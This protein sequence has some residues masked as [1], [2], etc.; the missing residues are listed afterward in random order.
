MSVRKIDREAEQAVLGTVLLSDRVL[1]ALAEEGLRPEHFASAQHRTIFTA[2]LSLAERAE[3]VDGQTLLSELKRSRGLADAGGEM[4]LEGLAG[5]VPNVGHV[6]AYARRVVEVA[7][8]ARVAQAGQRLL[9]AADGED[10][11]LVADAERLL[12]PDERRRDRASVQSRTFDYLSQQGLAGVPWPFRRLGQLANGGMMPGETTVIAGWSSHGK[13]IFTDQIL[14]HATM[15]GFTA[16]LYINEGQDVMRV[17]RGVARDTGVPFRKLRA[18]DLTTEQA[19]AATT[20]L[21]NG[22]PFEVVEARGWSAADISRDMRWHPRDVTAIDILHEI[23]F[24]DERALASNWT[25][26][27]AAAG[28]THLIATAHLNEARSVSDRPPAP[29]LRDIRNSGMIKNG[30]EFVLFVNREYEVVDGHAEM[31]RD[32]GVWFA[33]TRDGELGGV[34]VVLDTARMRFVPASVEM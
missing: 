8:W 17:L 26:L 22:L 16:R 31:T 2:M 11:G 23:D 24:A 12:A 19:K 27:K 29:A 34:K 6:R 9:E 33:K 28:E 20:S 13:S 30:T 21:A 14:H 5:P 18:R 7:R 3:P 15:K 4:V 25:T 32:G 10:E 1:P